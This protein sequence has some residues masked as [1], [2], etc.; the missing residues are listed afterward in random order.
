MTSVTSDTGLLTEAFTYYVAARQSKY[1]ADRPAATTLPFMHTR[2]GVFEH[3]L[4]FAQWPDDV[5]Y[6]LSGWE[7]A[8]VGKRIPRV[9]ITALRNGKPLAVTL[10]LDDLDDLHAVGKK[11]RGVARAT[12]AA[13][14]GLLAHLRMVFTRDA[15]LS[16]QY[17]VAFAYDRDI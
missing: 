12:G 3:A 16:E 8:T 1:A 13:L 15:P 6:A 4:R 14:D 10:H 7:I 11:C 5:P 2:A 9:R 17:L